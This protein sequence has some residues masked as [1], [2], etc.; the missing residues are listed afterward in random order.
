[1]VSPSVQALI[2]CKPQ[3]HLAGGLY[4][5]TWVDVP[6]RS[7]HQEEAV[8]GQCSSGK[9]LGTLSTVISEILSFTIV[10]RTT[11]TAG[12]SVQKSG[13]SRVMPTSS[14]S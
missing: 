8:I 13:H 12:P 6:P 7:L 10:R 5:F 3:S 1:M 4:D 9:K 11:S 2:E 14:G